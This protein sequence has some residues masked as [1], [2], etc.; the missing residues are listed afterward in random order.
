MLH[1]L[2]SQ[3]N[4]LAHLGIDSSVGLTAE[5]VG[6]SVA[7]Y[8]ANT[9]THVKPESLLKRLWHAVTEPMILL[10]I[11]A[12]LIAVA[13]NVIQSVTSGEV[14]FFDCAGIFIA[15]GISVVIT[16]VMEGKSAKAFEALSRINDD[17][18]VKALR[19]GNPTLL[20]QREIVVGDILLLATGA[21]IPADARL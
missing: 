17:A 20:H 1:F 12:W 8:G 7:K 19:D 6:E 11:G 14:D 15:I 9:L 13:V 10:L 21:K 3:E 5:S 4:C 18:V 2:S 16:L